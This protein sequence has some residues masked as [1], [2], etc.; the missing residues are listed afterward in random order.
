MSVE[1]DEDWDHLDKPS[2]KGLGLTDPV[3]TVEV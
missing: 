2:W 1:L 3:K